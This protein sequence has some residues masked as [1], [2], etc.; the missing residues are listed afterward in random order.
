MTAEPLRT[1]WWD[2]AESRADYGVSYVVVYELDEH[3]VEVPAA[4]AGW[5]QE[6]DLDQ[7]FWNGA[8]GVEIVLRC[9]NNYVRH[10]FRNRTPDLYQLAYRHRHEHVVAKLGLPAYSYLYEQPIPLHLPDGWEYHTPIDQPGESRARPGGELH[11]WWEMRR[12][13][14]ATA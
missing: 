4:W 3:G 2:D 14:C 1:Q 8:G 5:I 7:R 9:C 11:R 13:A 6:L 12:P 10:G